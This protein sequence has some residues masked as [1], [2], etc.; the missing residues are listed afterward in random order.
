[1]VFSFSSDV[2]LAGGRRLYR[3]SLTDPHGHSL[4]FQYEKRD[5]NVRLVAV[6]DAVGQATSIEYTSPSSTVVKRVEDPF[7]RSATL[8]YTSGLTITDMGGLKSKVVY[9]NY[10]FITSLATPYGVT[11]FAFG[12][13][14]VDNSLHDRTRWLEATDPL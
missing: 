12:D 2:D 11:R 8:D 13:S 10:G 5:G 3:T 14:L 7:G 1:E 4:R 9:G 6:V